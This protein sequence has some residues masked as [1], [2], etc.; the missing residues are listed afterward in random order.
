MKM[1]GIRGKML[2]HR[3]YLSY[4]SN[5]NVFAKD[6]YLGNILEQDI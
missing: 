3:D 4:C 2:C 5:K 1:M 6:V